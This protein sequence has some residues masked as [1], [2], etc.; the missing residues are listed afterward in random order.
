VWNFEYDARTI[1]DPL[2]KWGANNPLNAT[3]WHGISGEMLN[4]GSLVSL[5]NFLE[6]KVTPLSAGNNCHGFQMCLILCSP[7][8]RPRI[9]QV[10]VVSSRKFVISAVVQQHWDICAGVAMDPPKVQES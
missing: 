2:Q 4:N 1:Y 3:F 9:V 5:Y 7:V 8:R 6:T 10:R